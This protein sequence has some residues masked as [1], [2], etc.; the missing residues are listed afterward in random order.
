MSQSVGTVGVVCS[1]GRHN[2]L[3]LSLMKNTFLAITFLGAAA[4]S[5]S[6]VDVATGN[7]IVDQTGAPISGAEITRDTIIGGGL[8]GAVSEVVLD[9]PVFVRNGATLTINPGVT[10]RGNPR[11]GPVPASGPDTFA[12]GALIISRDGFVDVQ[13]TSTSPVVFTTAAVDDAAP[14]GV[15]DPDPV[16]GGLLDW[17]FGASF[18]DDTPRTAPLAPI[19]AAGEENVQLW[20]GVAILGEAPVNV[21]LTS[22]GVATRTGEANVEGLQFPGTPLDRIIYGGD[23]ANDTS[24]IFR[25]ASIRHAGD[26]IVTDDEL[27]GLVL[28]GVGYNTIVEFVEIYCNF[29]DG[30]EWFGG[31]VDSRFLAVFFAGDDSFD[32]D[33]GFTGRNQFWLNIMP[34]FNE[35]NGDNW[36][37]RSGDNSFEADGDDAGGDDTAIRV[38]LVNGVVDFISGSNDLLAAA[39]FSAQTVYN[40][41]SLGANPL[42]TDTVNLTNPAASPKTANGQLNLKA[43]WNGRVFNSIFANYGEANFDIE[44]G[45]SAG[46]VANAPDN[47]AAGTA[48]FAACTFQDVA[49]NLPSAADPVVAQ[50]DAFVDTFYGSAASGDNVFVSTDN[51]A[52]DNTWFD[53]QGNAA[54]KLDSTLK[55]QPID[56]RPTG[57]FGTNVLPLGLGYDE[58]TFRGAFAANPVLPLWTNGWTTLSAAGLLQ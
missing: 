24:G 49:G 46:D 43:G 17:S 8:N 10:V 16:N 15:A 57:N 40:W 21:N 25:F 27:N 53:P 35:N 58:V 32:L 9:G 56:P 51:I 45:A 6:I 36:G 33:Q 7:F 1:N 29:D 28:A 42:D 41:T 19:N 30:V 39:P 34:F 26:E 44:G 14:F 12:P 55:S 11:N 5:A 37:S 13:G 4:L 2:P 48:F 47:I 22:G 50:G 52:F 20:G 38:S 23:L 18:L 3:N 54:G 31:T